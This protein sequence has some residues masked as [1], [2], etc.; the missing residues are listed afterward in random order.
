[1]ETHHT[2]VAEE[3]TATEL[4]AWA[5]AEPVL[6]AW[7]RR[8]RESQFA[9]YTAAGSYTRL[10][11]SLG[12]PSV[13]LSAAAG[14][15]LFATLSKSASIE[16]RLF[17]AFVALSAAVLG[18][19]QTFLGLNA[20]AEQHRSTASRYGTIRRQ[21]EQYQATNPARNIAL[22]IQLEEVRRS[23]DDVAGS[24]PNVPDWAWKKAQSHIAD[25][26]RPEGFRR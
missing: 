16:L 10:S 20:L 8:A 26:E 22:G 21:I 7:Y 23:L 2:S 14:S 1:M 4:S 3:P 13:V 25:T 11:K 5:A 17:V 18:A 24:A 15:V 6:A 9:H 12:V 19:L